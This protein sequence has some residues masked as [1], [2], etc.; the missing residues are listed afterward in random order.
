MCVFPHS[1]SRAP[2]TERR[3]RT[4]TS[5]KHHRVCSQLRLQPIE[6]HQQ[7]RK[8]KFETNTT[9]KHITKESLLSKKRHCHALFCHFRTFDDFKCPRVRCHKQISNEIGYEFHLSYKLSTQIENVFDFSQNIQLWNCNPA[10]HLPE[11]SSCL[12]ALLGSV[13]LCLQR[14]PAPGTPPYDCLKHV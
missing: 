13:L 8:L 5:E 14:A 12:G 9:S 1:P 11:F 10:E 2:T 4:G 6:L 7:H 3:C